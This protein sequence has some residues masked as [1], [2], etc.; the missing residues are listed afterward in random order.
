MEGLGISQTIYLIL[1]TVGTYTLLRWISW[2][3]IVET[4]IV[5]TIGN[6]ITRSKDDKNYYLASCNRVF[7]LVKKV[8]IM[9]WIVIP[10]VTAILF[11]MRTI[12]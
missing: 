10:I 5:E 6:F 9:I 12:V 7:E 2:N 8:I 4:T 3:V 1:I 11:G